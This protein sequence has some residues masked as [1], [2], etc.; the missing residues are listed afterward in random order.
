MSD[1]PIRSF[2]SYNIFIRGF[3]SYLICAF[4]YGGM[5]V[6]GVLVTPVGILQI[7]PPFTEIW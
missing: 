4:V 5:S 1:E 2:L 6:F 7:T 3:P